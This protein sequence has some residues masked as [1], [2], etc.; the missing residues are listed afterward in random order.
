VAQFASSGIYTYE[1]KA[2]TTENCFAF[3]TIR[4]KVFTTA[5]DIYVPNAF[6]PGETQNNLFRPIPVGI[7]KFDYFRIYNRL[8]NMVFSSNDG[9]G[10][11]GTIAGKPQASGTFVWVVQGR[12]FTGKVITKK[13]TMVLI[14]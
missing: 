11:N 12:D 3:D 10:W 8:G 5:P 4:I 1:V 6:T 9:S 2:Y 7:A 13:G 14:R